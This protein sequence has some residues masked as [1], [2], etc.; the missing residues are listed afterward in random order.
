MNRRR[1]VL[2]LVA[3]LSGCGGGGPL[4]PEYPAM[5]EPAAP[6]APTPAV[7]SSVVEPLRD[8]VRVLEQRS[9]SPVVTVRVV[10]D[11]GSA[12]DPAGRE[13]VTALGAQLMVEGGAGERTYAQ[14]TEQLFP[15]AAQLSVGVDRDQTV[16]LGRVHRDRLEAFYEIFRDVLLRPRMQSEDFE[17]LR[18]QAQTG[19]T[20]ELRGNDDEALGKETLQAML[21]PAHPYGHPT[22]GTEQGL[23]RIGLDDVRAQRARVFCAGRATLGLAGG[24]PDGFA[25]RV[26]HDLGQ[27]SSEAC[28]GRASVPPAEAGDAQIWIVSKPDASSVA[29]SMGMPVDV[30]RGDPDYPA[31]VLA[32]AW[33][34]QHRQFV[35]RLMQSIRERRG[36]NYGDYAYP[37]HFEQ[38]GWGVFPRPNVARRVQHFSIWLRP[39]RPDQAHF[40]I[41]LALAE[42]RAL[43]ERGLTEDELTRIR[44]YLEGYYALFLQTES[45]RLGFAVDD[46]FYG[47]DVPWL[48]ALRASW[49]GLSAADVN[50]AIRRHLDPS[51]LQM[52][53]VAPDAEAFAERLASEQA[54]PMVY[55]G[56]SVGEDVLAQDR[57]VQGLRIGVPRERIRVVPLDELF[58]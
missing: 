7:V 46:A 38:D 10:F 39:L 8:A 58:R 12:D 22:L 16:F 27:L 47:Q 15:M 31:I 18:T 28:A 40:G 42:F 49:R 37:E 43:V 21:F 32:T 57:E 48:E 29:V 35:G 13:G 54:S 14:I 17:R 44:S 55:E 52:A 4:P 24:Y 53:I 45:R 23:S 34:G 41:R 1:T 11:A 2:A 25:A 5:P 56:R 30:E 3:A 36:M 50:A 6:P 20:L 33:L 26:A 51:R 9:A 19:L